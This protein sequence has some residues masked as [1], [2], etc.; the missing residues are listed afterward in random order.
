MRKTLI[1]TTLAAV[2]MLAACGGSG[3]ASNITTQLS[4]KEKIQ[5]LEATNALPKLDRSTTLSGA[6]LNA[7]GVRDDIDNY[8]TSMYTSHAQNKAAT[9]IA[10]VI[11]SAILVDKADSNSV[12]A[13]AI[14]TGRA[15]NCVFTQFT[16]TTG[17][18]GPA[19]VL[20]KLQ[21][22]TTN[23]KARLVAYL[24]FS[25]ALSGTV[26]TLPEGDTCD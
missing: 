3:S 6:D 19:V 2:S 13:I 20:S 25:N 8:I 10:K 11:Q 15:V 26:G 23:T 24:E 4:D 18:M 12:R 16:A 22:L 14:S 21:S 7:N 17:E 5:E 9:Q 1:I